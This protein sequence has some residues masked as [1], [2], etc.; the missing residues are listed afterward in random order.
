MP[1][2]FKFSSRTDW[3]MSANRLN[4]ELDRLRSSGAE[5]IDLTESNPTHCGFD[6]PKSLLQAFE[7]PDNLLYSPESKGMFSAR[8]VIADYHGGQG[9]KV[10][11][12]SVVLTSS[13]SEA[14]TFLF[15]LLLNPGEKVLIARPSYPLF[16]YLIELADAVYDFY[17][18][19]FENDRWSIDMHALE[20]AID[21]TTRVIV[22]V[23]PN[24]P[25]GSYIGAE[26][27]DELNRIC[28]RHNLALISDEVFFD[29]RLDPADRQGVSL[30]NN[31]KVPTFVLSGLSKTLGLP[32]M[33]LSWITASGPND[34]IDEALTRLDI[35]ADTFL[36]VNTPVQN[37]LGPWLSCRNNI[38]SGILERV[39]CNHNL[40]RE[41]CLRHNGEFLSSRGGWYAVLQISSIADEEEWIIDLLT[42]KHVLVHPGYFFDFQEEGFIVL[43]LLPKYD[44]MKKGLEA[45]SG[46]IR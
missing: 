35:I 46:M 15:R 34:Y 22:L 18:L 25:T 6:Y 5:I 44:Q 21:H 14:Y 29:Y 45:I 26:E 23:N 27:L 1:S 7:N 8:R 2:D 37:A 43:S 16:Q 31:A 32:Q 36:S 11:P 38:Q 10:D 12:Q 28:L 17:P 9:K 4:D 20:A 3:E 41:F 33:K 24:N 30:V 39:R 40:V 19:I 42:E 13:T